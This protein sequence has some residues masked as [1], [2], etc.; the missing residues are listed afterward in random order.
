M[1]RLRNDAGN[2]AIAF[3]KFDCL[4]SPKPRLQLS[5][6]SKLPK[7][8]LRHY[9]NVSHYVSHVNILTH[10]LASANHAGVFQSVLLSVQGR[11]VQL[12]HMLHGSIG[13]LHMAFNT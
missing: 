1:S 12:H 8:N 4:A 7:V 11:G 10:T 13:L 9:Q 3:V 6:V 5:S 2:H